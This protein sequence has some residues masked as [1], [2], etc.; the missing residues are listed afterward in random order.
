MSATLI[1]TNSAM[2]GGASPITTTLAVQVGDLICVGGGAFFGDPG[3]GSVWSCTDD[4]GHTYNGNF[5]AAG[6]AFGQIVAFYAIA[7][8]TA[9]ITISLAETMV[10][11][12]RYI[13]A[14]NYRG[15]AINFDQVSTRIGLYTPADAAM[16]PEGVGTGVFTFGDSLIV[17]FLYTGDDTLASDTGDTVAVRLMRMSQWYRTTSSGGN[18]QVQLKHTPSNLIMPCLAMVFSTPLTRPGGLTVQ[19]AI[20]G[21]AGFENVE[22]AMNDRPTNIP[23]NRPLTVSL[24]YLPRVGSLVLVAVSENVFVTASTVSDAYGNMYTQLVSSTGSSS[25]T[26][27]FYTIVAA[28]PS[29]GSVFQVTHSCPLPVT[30]NPYQSVTLGIAEFVAPINIAGVQTA[31]YLSETGVSPSVVINS[32]TIMGVLAGSLVFG[33]A[34]YPG[35]V[36]QDAISWA[37]SAGY[38]ILSTQGF[39]QFNGQIVNRQRVGEGVLFYQFAPT[40]GNYAASATGTITGIFTSAGGIALIAIPTVTVG[41]GWA[42]VGS[43]APSRGTCAYAG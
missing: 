21:G 4:A 10:R 2:N 25:T 18:G 6:P 16:F 11:T 43:A 34:A 20:R 38:T 35:G 29:D 9:T 42:Y 27:I 41:G 28:V 19:S 24:P 32:N 7:I 15:T 1:N 5:R 23:L 40:A 17:S 37:L 33:I 26:R 31:T 14:A 22:P 36:N 39:I 3:D 30:T 12:D 13:V 8:S